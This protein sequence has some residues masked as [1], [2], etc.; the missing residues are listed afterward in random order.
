MFTAMEA[1]AQDAAPAL[2]QQALGGLLYAIS[3]FAIM[4]ANKFVLTVYGFPSFLFL[5]LSQFVATLIL[6]Q[7]GKSLRLLSYSGFGE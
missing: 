3:S 7:V 2:R 4:F 5:A 6:L 1:P